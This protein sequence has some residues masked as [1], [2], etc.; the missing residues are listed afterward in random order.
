M[1]RQCEQCGKHFEPLRADARYCKKACRQ[2]AY[3][4]RRVTDIAVTP[5]VGPD[6]SAGF[7]DPYI[8][9]GCGKEILAR[10]GCRHYFAQHPVEPKVSWDARYAA[11][12]LELP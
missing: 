7:Y 5:C 2:A 12:T 1:T 4:E 11:G 10:W 3:R 9:P 8:C 6:E